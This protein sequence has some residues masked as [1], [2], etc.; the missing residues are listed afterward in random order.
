V[1]LHDAAL[2]VDV[3]VGHDDLE[4]H[5]IARVFPRR[6]HVVF[7]VD[8]VPVGRA[9]LL[10][11]QQFFFRHALALLAYLLVEELD[12]LVFVDDAAERPG[13]GLLEQHRDRVLTFVFVSAA[14]LDE[15]LALLVVEEV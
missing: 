5:L 10:V 15:A 3:E 11:E 4:E 8:P 6:R 7:P 14:Q 9:V 1:Q 13:G 12:L 2:L